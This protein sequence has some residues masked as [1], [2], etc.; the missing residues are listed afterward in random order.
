MLKRRYVHSPVASLWALAVSLAA[1]L[2][3]LTVLAACSSSPGT[4]SSGSAGSNGP[5]LTF[6]EQTHDFGQISRS[7]P[8]TYNFAFT[9]TGSAPLQISSVQP[10]PIDPTNCT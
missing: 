1:A 6:K 4:N 2:V 8:M 10:E 7:K 5:Q 3:A 9:N